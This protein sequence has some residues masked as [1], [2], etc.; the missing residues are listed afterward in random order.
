M[1]WQ[2]LAALARAGRAALM[3]WATVDDTQR[4]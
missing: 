1:E 2:S 4:R 3:M